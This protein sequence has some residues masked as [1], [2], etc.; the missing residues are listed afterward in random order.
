MFATC[1]LCSEPRELKASHVIPAFVFRWLRET[2]GTGHLRFNQQPN[3]REQDGP[4][5]AW[6]CEACEGDLGRFESEFAR[7]IF[8]PY[9]GNENTR[10]LYGPWLLKFAASVSWRVL[11]YF[12]QEDGLKDFDPTAKAAIQS[13]NL[14]W[15]RFLRGEEPHPGRHEQH[16]VPF[17]ALEATSIKS[18]PPNINRYLMRAVASDLLRM[19]EEIIVFT[20]LGRFAIFGFVSGNPKRWKGTKINA[21]QGW[22][23]PRKYV[24]PGPIGNYLMGKAREIDALWQTISPKQRQKI[25]QSF[26]QNIDAFVGSDAFNA[27]NQDFAMFGEAAFSKDPEKHG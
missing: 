3:R 17:D 5:R 27:L 15:R 6:L 19:G 11:K 8:H 7:R 26:R 13:A 10:F 20:K 21:N 2:S 24:L 23:E 25:D 12:E 18:P 22:I 1:L 16:I 9:V 14:T 4:T